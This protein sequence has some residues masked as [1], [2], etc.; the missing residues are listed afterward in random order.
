M[1][2][3]SGSEG[4]GAFYKG[5]ALGVSVPSVCPSLFLCEPKAKLLVALINRPEAGAVAV[6]SRRSE[7]SNDLSLC[8]HGLFEGAGLEKAPRH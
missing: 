4:E 6:G 8:A 3:V 5:L 1:I 2:C 7:G